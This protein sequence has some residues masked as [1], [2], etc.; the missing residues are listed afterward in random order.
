MEK[1]EEKAALLGMKG[2]GHQEKT[3]GI[4]LSPDIT[5]KQTSQPIRN[6]SDNFLMQNKTA[7]SVVYLDMAFKL[8]DF[9]IK[10]Q[11]PQLQFPRITVL[12]SLP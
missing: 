12:Y 3:S 5:N 2:S 9:L 7:R 8:E 1:K 4:S 6:P 11:T 10:F